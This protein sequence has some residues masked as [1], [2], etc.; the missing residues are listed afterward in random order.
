MS[1]FKLLQYGRR[2]KGK[3][4]YVRVIAL[5]PAEAGY[6]LRIEGRLHDDL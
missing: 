2:V 1:Q 3:I 6:K 5:K 4:D